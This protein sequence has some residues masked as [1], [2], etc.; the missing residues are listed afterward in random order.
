MKNFLFVALISLVAFSC[1]KEKDENPNSI[2]GTWYLV[3]E[4]FTTGGKTRTQE[5]DACKGKSNAVFSN[6]E[7]KVTFFYSEVK[8]CKLDKEG[9]GTYT[10]TE[11]KIILKSAGKEDVEATLKDGILTLKTSVGYDTWKKR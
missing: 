2:E 9:K 10:I 4:T 1:N 6:G 5:A 7:V 11:G 8:E 3:S